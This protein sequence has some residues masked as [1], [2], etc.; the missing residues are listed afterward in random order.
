MTKE[1]N[2]KRTVV[3]IFGILILILIILIYRFFSIPS[4]T[5]NHENLFLKPHFG[6]NETNYYI[7]DTV[8]GH[9]HKP[10]TTREFNWDEHPSGKIITSTN[11]L[12]F[13]KDSN[14]RIEKK[15][16]TIRVLVT[17][18][19]HTDGVIYNSESFSNQL[20]KKFNNKNI[21]NFDFLNA[22]AGY[23]GP[24]N[25]LGVLKRYQNLNP[26][27][28]IVTVY[29]G[30]DFL[31]A[32]RIE[33][34]NNRLIVPE[35]N[36]NYYSD[37]WEIDEKYPGFTGQLMNQ[38]KFFK[39]F[40]KYKSKAVSISAKN[41]SLIKNI[42]DTNGIQLYVV[43][44]PTKVDIESKF[45][46]TRIK[47]VQDILNFSEKDMEIN[48]LLTQQLIQHLKKN[49]ISFLNLSDY[50]VDKQMEEL[51]WKKDYHINN[52]GHKRIADILSKRIK[53]KK[54]IK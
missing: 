27:V 48:Q 14:T 23:Y 12:G 10:N 19:S 37:L 20:E 17:G 31:D 41:I 32:I 38:I 44:L 50:W 54:G 29:T 33:A 15:V 36:D 42:C 4:I 6:E 2:I 46:S 40:P 30:N 45:D 35:R 47:E 24:Q 28:F 43:L 9:I 53:L 34:E 13:R 26:N 25:Y 11:N 18:D 1:R 52:K 22:G 3:I 39:T 5:L 7:P 16:N 49:S 8:A 51:Y 21:G